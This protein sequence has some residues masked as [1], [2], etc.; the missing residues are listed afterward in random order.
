MDEP[1]KIIQKPDGTYILPPG[2]SSDLCIRMATAVEGVIREA[3]PELLPA[4]KAAM[5]RAVEIWAL[6]RQFHLSLYEEK[7]SDD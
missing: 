2:S 5:E 6:E 3:A 4:I 1:D 7:S